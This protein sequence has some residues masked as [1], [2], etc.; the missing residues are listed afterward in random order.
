[1]RPWVL[2]ED[3]CAGRCYACFSCQNLGENLLKVSGKLADCASAFRETGDWAGDAPWAC[4][5]VDVAKSQDIP[6]DMVR[7]ESQI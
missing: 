5:K 1:M 4:V 3:C 2:V 6:S 7:L